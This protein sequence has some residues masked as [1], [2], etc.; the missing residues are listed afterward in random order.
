MA[1][2]DE[3][4]TIIGTYLITSVLF[5]LAT[6]VIWAVNTLFLLHA[7]LNLFQVFFVNAI[8]SLGDLV[9][10]LA[11]RQESQK[12][13]ALLDLDVVRRLVRPERRLAR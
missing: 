2:S 4:R 11:L 3:A 5:T 13:T 8:F 9:F 1:R 10:A 7:G 6:S 12:E